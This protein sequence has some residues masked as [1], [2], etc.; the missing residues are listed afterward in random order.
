[1]A[2]G[3]IGSIFTLGGG[4][5]IVPLLFLVI[6]VPMHNA[7]ATALMCVIA[8][9]KKQREMSVLDIALVAGALAGAFIF[10]CRGDVLPVVTA[11]V[12]LGV[13]AGS[14]AGPLLVTLTAPLFIVGVLADAV[15]PIAFGT[16]LPA[17]IPLL[18]RAL[19]HGSPAAMIHIG[20]LIMKI[21]ESGLVRHPGRLARLWRGG[22]RSRLG[23]GARPR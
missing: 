4:I 16:I 11:T 12:L 10:Y 9:R 2:A 6:K 21:R 7:V 8:T 13:L 23:A 5:V 14:R 20:I 18:P 3:V 15:D 19:I 22:A 17:H 1:V